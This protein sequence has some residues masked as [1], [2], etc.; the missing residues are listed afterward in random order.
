MKIFVWEQ[1]EITC[2]VYY[3]FGHHILILWKL[4]CMEYADKKGNIYFLPITK[5]IEL[6]LNHGGQSSEQ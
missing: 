4:L 6:V 2:N 5:I 3:I 1:V